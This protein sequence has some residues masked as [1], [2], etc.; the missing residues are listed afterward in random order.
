MVLP[1]HSFIQVGLCIAKLL[2]LHDFDLKEVYQVQWK[3]KWREG[4][5]PHPSLACPAQGWHGIYH[6]A[7]GKELWEL[8][9]KVSPA[10]SPVKW[11]WFMCK[12]DFSASGNGKVVLCGFSWKRLSFL[13]HNFKHG[14]IHLILEFGD[15]LI[16]ILTAST[17]CWRAG[18]VA[19]EPVRPVLLPWANQHRLGG[20]W[21]IQ[22]H[23]PEL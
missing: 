12:V 1:Q 16:L 4:P 11:Q 6:S 8:L 10:A 3:N 14:S 2:Q 17:D 15:N 22:K 9:L 7:G 18:C 5:T 23:E 13:K 21:G 20:S 19:G